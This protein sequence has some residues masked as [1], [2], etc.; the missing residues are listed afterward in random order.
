VTGVGLCPTTTTCQ[1]GIR[2]PSGKS[3]S[4]FLLRICSDYTTY[5]NIELRDEP[6]DRLATNSGPF[7]TGIDQTY[8]WVSCTDGSP[9]YTVHTG[10]QT[11]GIVLHGSAEGIESYAQDANEIHANDIIFDTG[12]NGC[13]TCVGGGPDQGHGHQIYTQSKDPGTKLYIGNALLAGTSLTVQAYTTAGTL[14][15][16]TFQN[17][18]FDCPACLDQRGVNRQSSITIGSGDPTIVLLN[19]NWTG[20][21]VMCGPLPTSCGGSS[22]MYWGTSSNCTGTKT[23]VNNYDMGH[24]LVGNGTQ[25]STAVTATGN[26]FLYDPVAVAPN[27]W[28]KA[29]YPTNTYKGGVLPTVDRSVV[30]PFTYD[31]GKCFVKIYNWDGVGATMSV[32]LD[33]CL[34]NGVNYEIRNIENVFAAPVSTGTFTTGVSVSFPTTA[35]SVF[36]PAGDLNGSGVGALLPQATGTAGI[37]SNTFLV[38]TTSGG[39]NTPTPTFT[40]TNTPTSTSTPTLTP[41]RTNTPTSTPTGTLPTNTPTLTPSLTLTPTPTFTRSPTPAS[42]STSFPAFGCTYTAPMAAHADATAIGLGYG[43][44]TVSGT[45]TPASG[46][47]FTCPFTV[48]STGTYRMWVHLWAADF[49]SDSMYAQ[50]GTDPPPVGATPGPTTEVFDFAESLTYNAGPPSSC[51]GQQQ[52]GTVWQWNRLNNRGTD[53]DGC[54]GIGAERLLSLTAGANSVTFW[55]REVGARVDYI[56]L[57]T[58][59]NYNPNTS[60]VAT[61]TPGPNQCKRSYLCNRNSVIWRLEPCNRPPANPCPN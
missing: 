4:S 52:F 31:T 16:I 43:S 21:E 2:A 18:I 61:P 26:T 60:F 17:N 22:D 55:G 15:N 54:T 44:T 3:L 42:F 20:N 39:A 10:N 49:S 11:H 58:D 56:I 51:V 8:G 28:S 46:G 7:A 48:P 14:D 5:T 34:Q 30:V 1:S 32:N 57:T 41:S 59:L 53:G 38:Q 9:N 33:S 50:L 47:S 25:C 6:L 23:I 29:T 37:G 19:P 13:P 35:L 40:T 27:T 24:F 36:T 12:W 45:N